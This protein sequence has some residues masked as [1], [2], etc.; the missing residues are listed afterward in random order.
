MI[1][2]SQRLQPRKLAQSPK[3]RK[4]WS[5]VSDQKPK[6]AVSDILHNG[7]LPANTYP[8]NTTSHHRAHSHCQHFAMSS[9]ADEGK[10]IATDAI[11]RR[12]PRIRLEQLPASLSADGAW[13]R[14]EEQIGKVKNAAQR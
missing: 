5:Q 12:P 13:M 6:V 2:A 1:L 3:R 7:I 14:L 9:Q 10:R 8:R 4:P 11:G